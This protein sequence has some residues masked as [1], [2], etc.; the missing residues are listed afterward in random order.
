MSHFSLQARWVLPIERPP[1]AGG[2]VSIAGGIISAVGD[3]PS[4]DGPLYDL[5]N[6]V[7]MPALVNTHTHL[8]FSQLDKPLGRPGMPLPEWIRLVIANRQGAKQNRDDDILSGLHESLRHGVT[9]IGDITSKAASRPVPQPAPQLISFQEA[10][11]FSAARVDSALTDIRQ[12]IKSSHPPAALSPHAPYTVHPKLLERLVDLA[13]KQQMPIAMHL[14][15]SPEELELLASASGPFRELLLERSMW[16]DR[17]IPLGTKPIDYLKSLARAPRSLAIHGN[18]FSAEEIEFLAARRERMS[19]VY[20]PRTHA[21]FEHSLYPLEQMLAAG[22]RV[23][24]GTDSR[25]SNP[26]LNLLNEMRFVANRYSGIPSSRILAMGTLAGAQALGLEEKIGSLEPGKWA[27][28]VAVA[29]DAE[30]QEPEAAI[31]HDST[32]TAKTWLRGLLQ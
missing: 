4:G 24:L 31:L 18:Y 9:T 22:V 17:A 14:A 21:Y 26:D 25:A 16:D 6:V 10:I 29:C 30:C 15:E 12:R 20:C 8:E 28:L 23:A 13:C 1:I 27:D 5:G 7:L 32:V 2:V 11:G 3:R 19:V